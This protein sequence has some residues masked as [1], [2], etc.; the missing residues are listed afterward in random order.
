MIAE[1]CAVEDRHRAETREI[2]AA[3]I[4]DTRYLCDPTFRPDRQHQAWIALAASFAEEAKRAK[5]APG[6]VVPLPGGRTAEQIIAAGRRL[7]G[8]TQR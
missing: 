2:V 7:R 6:N 8:E 5:A 1:M 3:A 4:A